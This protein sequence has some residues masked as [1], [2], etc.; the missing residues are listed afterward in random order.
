MDEVN[1]KQ[2]R[3]RAILYSNVKGVGD[4]EWNIYI[5]DAVKQY[6][7][8]INAVQPDYNLKSSYFTTTSGQS[9]YTFDSDVLHIRK[10]S[11]HLDNDPTLNSQNRYSLRTF[12]MTETDIYCNTSLYGQYG[13]Q[14]LRYRVWDGVSILFQPIPIQAYMIVYY[15]IPVPPTLNVDSDAIN[16]ISGLDVYISAVAAKTVLDSK[17]I[18]NPSLDVKIARFVDFLTAVSN[19]HDS[20]EAQAIE[21]TSYKGRQWW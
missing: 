15:Y 17:R 8:V 5:N 16:G 1:L 13:A 12:S 19:T 6:W 18:S 3:D 14:S 7:N 11:C 21:D 20:D 2:L 10:V 9:Q 4:D